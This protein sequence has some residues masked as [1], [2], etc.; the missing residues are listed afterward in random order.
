MKLAM[1]EERDK[2]EEE[3]QRTID[4][5]QR[6]IDE[7]KEGTKKMT[8]GLERLQADLKAMKETCTCKGEAGERP[9]AKG[10]RSQQR[11]KP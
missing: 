2:I 7:L 10:T 5:K 1:I 3:M 4:D 11:Q 9:V 8:E 6:V